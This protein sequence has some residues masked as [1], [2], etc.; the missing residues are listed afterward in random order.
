[1]AKKAA[2]PSIVLPTKRSS[3]II[4]MRDVRW[5]LHGFP[6]VGKTTLAS[7]F[8]EVLFI[9]TEV[10]TKGMS[11]YGAPVEC[12]ADIVDVLDLLEEDPKNFETVCIDT[13][14][15]AHL[16]ACESVAED[17]GVSD[18]SEIAYGGGWREANRRIYKML[19]DLYRQ[20]GV[21]LISHTRVVEYVYG[22]KKVNKMVPDLSDSP[23]AVVTGWVDGI[24]Y[25]EVYEGDVDDDDD[26]VGETRRRVVCQPSPYIE[27]GGRAPF[28]YMPEEIDLGT[29]PAE[30]FD[31]LSAAFDD[32]AKETVK[33][34]GAASK[35]GATRR[36]RK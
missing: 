13:I 16:F 23:R 19:E 5:H 20:F 12:W 4:T 36:R 9:Q 24:L 11:I 33:Q 29:T 8:G 28:Q 15:R 7:L 6:K 3:S 32:A 35:G 34:H 31:N 21:V 27:A 10:G 1:M 17:N 22:V 30:G 2:K 25:L 26:D 18:L 14:E